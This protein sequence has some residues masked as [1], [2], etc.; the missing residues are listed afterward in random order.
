M[1]ML[2]L[3]GLVIGSPTPQSDTEIPCPLAYPCGDIT[4]SL[5]YCFN[6]TDAPVYGD[7]TFK[8]ET[9]IEC[10]C[11]SDVLGDE[12]GL[13]AA[14]ECILCGD[15]DKESSALVELWWY[16]CATAYEIG[17]DEALNCWNDGTDCYEPDAGVA[18]LSK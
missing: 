1:S 18:F 2:G 13:Y 16:T 8:D 11:G 7:G 5:S 6:V 14:T 10:V 12:S 4:V 3:C 15:L 17:V 9:P